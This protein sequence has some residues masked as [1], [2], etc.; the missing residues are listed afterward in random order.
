[1]WGN[2]RK[3]KGCGPVGEGGQGIW[4]EGARR[5]EQLRRLPTARTKR[6]SRC[7]GTMRVMAQ[8]EDDPAKAGAAAT[9]TR[10]LTSLVDSGAIAAIGT[11][12]AEVQ[13]QWGP[14]RTALQETLVSFARTRDAIAAS[15]DWAEVSKWAERFEAFQKWA[16]ELPNGLK[17]ALYEDAVL[18]HSGLSL[19]DLRLVTDEFHANGSTAAVAKVDALH[20]ELFADESF[21]RELS[22]RWCESHRWPVLN[23]LL[24]AHDAGLYGVTVPAA[25]AQAEGIVADKVCHKGHLSQNGVVD[26]VEKLSDPL[27][28]PVTKRFAEVILGTRFRHGDPVPRFSRHAIMHGAD[29]SYGTREKSLRLLVWVDYLLSADVATKETDR[30]A[31]APTESPP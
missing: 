16:D 2:P 26:H 19:H 31:A 11:R 6:A 25:L 10:W 18:P 7:T 3:Y 24:A 12:L 21:R 28:G 9:G 23:D 20:V 13:E 22:A 30:P 5:D 17:E 15:I 14:M 8:K 4:P 27:F 1:M 29:L